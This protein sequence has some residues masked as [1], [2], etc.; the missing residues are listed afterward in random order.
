MGILLW[1][2]DIGVVVDSILVLIV[3]GFV[4]FVMWDN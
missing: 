1:L 4:Y 3:E 2:N